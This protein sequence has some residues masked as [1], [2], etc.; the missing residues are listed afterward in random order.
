METWRDI[1]GYETCYEVSDHGQVRSK[2]HV[3]PCKGGTRLVRGKLKKL[4][5]NKTGYFIT[6]LSQ[7]NQ[8][9]TFTVHQLVAQSFLPGFTKGMPINHIDG[10]KTNNCISNLEL[11][12]PSH[13]MQHAVNTGLMPKVGVSAYRNVSYISNPAAI[14]KWA[15]CIN[16]NGKSSYGWKT[17][18]KEIEAAVYADQLLNSIGDTTRLRNF[19]TP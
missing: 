16:H 17:F 11:T 14:S 12:N 6:T 9:A 5:H 8:L 7:N 4:F 10:S 3:V 18:K 13:N 1:P 19:P 15:V 2:D